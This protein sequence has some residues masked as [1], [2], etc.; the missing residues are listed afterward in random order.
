MGPLMQ[1][2]NPHAAMN[3]LGNIEDELAE[4]QDEH[5]K[6]QGAVKGT[7]QFMK[8]FAAALYDEVEGD[9][10][11]EKK[12]RAAALMHASDEYI[13]HLRQIKRLEELKRRFEYLESRKSI[14][15]SILGYH[16]AELTSMQ[17][18]QHQQTGVGHD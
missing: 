16:K 12:E 3:A 15:Q 18:Q 9:S 8:T 6:L 1:H 11:A 10:A 17:G 5:S 2:D 4:M 14:G 7:E 13:E